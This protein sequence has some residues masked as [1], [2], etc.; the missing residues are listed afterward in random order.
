MPF[1]L[2]KVLSYPDF[3]ISS[4]FNAQ[5]TILEKPQH[6]F[7]SVSFVLSAKTYLWP[8]LVWDRSMGLPLHFL[9]SLGI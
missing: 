7:L 4:L 6:Y 3:N 9:A 1:A 8:L 5:S 2:A